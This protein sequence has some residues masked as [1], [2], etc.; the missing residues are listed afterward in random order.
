MYVS[1]VELRGFLQEGQAR[2]GVHHVL[3]YGHEVLGRQGAA[4]PS[5]QDVH[6]ARRLVVALGRH[7]GMFS[8]IQCRNG[9]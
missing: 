3:H 9:Y 1:R 6:E 8:E 5:G 2:V 7:S 4:L